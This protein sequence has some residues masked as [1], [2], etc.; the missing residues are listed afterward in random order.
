MTY[1]TLASL[2]GTQD[3]TDILLYVN[4]LTYGVAMPG[5]LFGFMFILFV[6]GMLLRY[7]VTGIMSPHTSFAAA[8]FVTFGLAVLMSLRSGLLNPIYLIISLVLAIV[9]AIWIYNTE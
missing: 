6:G 2:N 8:S 3:L 7:R 9:G 4:D 1:S 5:V